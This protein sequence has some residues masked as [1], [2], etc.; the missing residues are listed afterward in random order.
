MKTKISILTLAVVATGAM[1]LTGCSGDD[2]STPTIVLEGDDPFIVELGGTYTEPG[3]TATD[4]EDGDI[5][6]DVTVDES[7]VNTSSIGEYEVSYSVS[8]KAGNVGT[9]TRIVRVVMTKDDYLGSYS[10][11]E[12]CDLDGDGVKGEAGEIFDYSVTVT[13]GGDA[14]ELIFDNFGAYGAGVI[15]PVYFSGDLEEVLSVD[16]YNLP[17]TTVYFDATGEVTTG[18]TSDIVFDLSYSAQD[19]GDIVPCDATFTKL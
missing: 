3:F 7:A 6:A 13:S 12:L 16:H 19:G 15:V 1:Y 17:G 18:T 11:H 14:D 2:L 9:T 4:D 5:S 10:V 8:D